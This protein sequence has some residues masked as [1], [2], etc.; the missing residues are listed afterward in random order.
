MVFERIWL[1]LLNNSV[2]IAASVSERVDTGTTSSISLVRPWD[3]G[4]GS[5]DFVANEINCR[6][7]GC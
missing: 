5:L 4:T 7:A 1:R 6:D 2:S 3:R